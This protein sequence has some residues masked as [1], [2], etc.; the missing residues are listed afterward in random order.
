MESSGSRSLPDVIIAA[1]GEISRPITYGTLIGMLVV[2]PILALPGAQAAFFWPLAQS[3]ILALLAA[4]LVTFLVIP[5]A[6]ILLFKQDT[7]DKPVVFHRATV[8]LSPTKDCFP[9]SFPG[10]RMS[11]SCLA[12]QFWRWL[13][14]FHCSSCHQFPLSWNVTLL[15]PGRPRPEHRCKA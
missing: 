15:W 2:V 6:A 11:S 13:H 1:M 10:R 12:L 7:V 3:Y 14:H 4:G 9:G 8:P 5:G